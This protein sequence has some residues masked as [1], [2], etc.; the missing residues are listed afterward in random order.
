ERTTIALPVLFT[1]EHALAKLWMSWGVRPQAMIG[2]SLGEYAAACLAGVMSLEDALAMVALRARLIDTLP[3]G[4]MLTVPLPEEEIAPELGGELAIAAVNGP[5]FC[6]VSGPAEAIERAREAWAARGVDARRLHIA[7]AGH[8]PVV[9]PILR[10][11]GDFV[12]TLAL[13]PPRIPY[14]SNVT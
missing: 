2:H 1:V 6:V 11:F 5:A 13:S 3:A 14:I 7:A 10:E 12:A 4:G 8:S 9:E